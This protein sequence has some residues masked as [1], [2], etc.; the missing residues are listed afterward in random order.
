MRL[1]QA[2][3]G[4][5]SIAACAL[6]V[7][8]LGGGRA[9]AHAGLD[10][11]VPA[12]SSVLTEGPER[13]VLDYDEAVEAST[14]T[15]Q[16]Y[17]ET[18]ASIELGEPVAGDG[19]DTVI[20]AEVP[21]IG[22]G[23]YAV[24]WRVSSVDGHVVDGA[25]SF[26]VGTANGGTVGDDLIDQV[27]EGVRSPASVRVAYGIGRGAAYLGLSVLVGGGALVVL[28]G[29]AVGRRLRSLFVG[30]WGLAV[31]GVVA[32]IGC[33][34]ATLVGA[35]LGDALTFAHWSGVGDTS[36]GRW[37]L[38]RL[39]LVLSAGA[40]VATLSL[41]HAG[42]WRATALVAV[43]GLLL[44]YPMV[45]HAAASSPV[46]LWALIGGLHTLGV[47]LWVGGLL[48][49]VAGRHRWLVAAPAPGAAPV[50]APGPA[51]GSASQ[52]DE[53]VAGRFSRTAVIAV[54]VIVA[55]GIAQTLEV[56]DDLDDLTATGWGRVLLVKLV[57]V[58]GLVVLGGLSRTLLRHHG[59]DSIR[60][61]VAVEAVL[62][63]VVLGLAASL[64]GLPPENAPS[65]QVFEVSLAEAGL[66]ADVTVTPGRVGSNEVHV[67][68]V[69]PGGNLQPVV[70][71]IGRMDLEE[72]GISNLVVDISPSG[73]N[74]FTG[75]VTLP[76]SGDWTLE[77]VVEVSPG[78]TTLLSTVV[79]IP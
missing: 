14:A 2:A 55:T 48:L 35:G 69:P 65:S 6:A 22:D 50:P 28:A 1:R 12:A 24:V 41:A 11:S 77:L 60:R 62:G 56:V 36:T 8:G 30:A 42:W 10:S 49:L 63:V 21:E 20:S 78:A 53:R 23:V 9:A 29:V 27:R 51:S 31:L 58:V 61:T 47:L 72:R 13:I 67:I 25:F 57:V 59:A 15:I 79:P 7:L 18:G 38:L 73:T 39:G 52:E 40:L 26:Q 37:L 54:P 5:A 44:T 32:S 3:G 76:F 4:V 71:L 64:V 43:V 34:G 70:G 46:P 75:R 19:D 45:G 33:Y 68:V 17:D 66:I 74:H 16:L